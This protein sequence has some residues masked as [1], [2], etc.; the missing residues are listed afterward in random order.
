MVEPV[1]A[2]PATLAEA[3]AAALAAIAAEMGENPIMEQLKAS[4]EADAISE[5]W[6]NALTTTPVKEALE[7][8]SSHYLPP[9]QSGMNLL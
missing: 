4:K 3:E 2:I 1:T 7:A 6:T 8:L 9:V 5:V